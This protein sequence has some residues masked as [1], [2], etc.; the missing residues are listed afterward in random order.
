MS[1]P[2]NLDAYNAELDYFE[3]ALADPTGIRI[4]FPDYGKAN[5]FTMRM[6]QARSLQRALHK[7]IYTPDDVR[8][9]RSE[10]DHLTVRQPREDTAGNWWVYVERTNATVISVEPLSQALSID[11]A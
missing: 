8:H 11:D 9:G 7:R 5:I 2:N 1:L 3:Q 6:H 10:F 4:Q